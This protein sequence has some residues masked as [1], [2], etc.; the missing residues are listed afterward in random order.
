MEA[1]NITIVDMG[2]PGRK[3]RA[4]HGNFSVPFIRALQEVKEDINILAVPVERANKGHF[5]NADGVIF[6]GALEG[7]ND[8]LPWR[9]KF[10]PLATEVIDSDT[11]VLGV[12]FG[13]QYISQL[14]GGK[15]ITDFKAKEHSLI[16]VSLNDQGKVDPLFKNIDCSDMF[17]ATHNDRVAELA[18]EA[19]RLA[20]S[21]LVD[22]HAFKIGE[23]SWGVQ[24][25]PEFYFEIMKD[26]LISEYQAGEKLEEQ[27][28]LAMK[29]HAGQQILSNFI[30][31]V[32]NLQV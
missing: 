7:V 1:L 5:E 3:M 8:D 17:Y 21:E 10:D 20:S 4:K 14:K 25:H 29:P 28:C 2:F 15:V 11:P 13:H 23:N 18:P 30:D 26:C 27:I 24:F 12:C 19:V 6:S 9:N 16:Q 22:N 32:K 31:I